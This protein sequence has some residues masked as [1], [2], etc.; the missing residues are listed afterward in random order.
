MALK[1]VVGL[2]KPDQGEVWVDGENVAELE[3]EELYELRRNVGY[4]F[5]FAALFDSMTVAENVGLGLER[6]EGMTT[7]QIRDR[8]AECL[9]VVE[10][11]GF[12]HLMVLHQ[13]VAV[14]LK[15]A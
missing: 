3:Q 8:V 13:V 2:L 4:V 6:I 10:L 5:Q 1:H 12:V 14:Q 9:D 7:T 15:R 11:E